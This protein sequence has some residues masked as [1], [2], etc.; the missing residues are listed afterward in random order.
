MTDFVS[1]KRN[2]TTEKERI[3]KL[4]QSIKQKLSTSIN[5]INE[6]L[7]FLEKTEQTFQQLDTNLNERKR[8]EI[9]LNNEK[10]ELLNNIDSLKEN[11]ERINLTIRDEEEKIRKLSEEQ[12][13]LEKQL[14][15]TK[16]ELSSTEALST[17][18]KEDIQIK[19]Q[20]K[21]DTKTRMDQRILQAQKSLEV[22]QHEE[23]QDIQV[24]PILDFLLK[25]VRI[26][27]PEVEILSVLAY[28]NQA[29]GIEELKKAVSKTPPVIILKVIRNLDSKGIIKYDERLD[30]IE[31]TA[32]LV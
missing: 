32:N 7:S 18:K 21:Q 30:T 31:I 27:I 10:K 25:E 5:E 29:I 19:I 26:D 2:I 17:K 4:E 23:D 20:E 28:R 24:S 13:N 11:I 6:A 14:N 15:S 16:I 12:M 22:L 3:E 9:Q 1:L 8:E